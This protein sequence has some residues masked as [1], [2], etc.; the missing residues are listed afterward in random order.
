MDDVISD[1][2]SMLIHE[3]NVW[4]Q[5]DKYISMGAK[6]YLKVKRNYFILLMIYKNKSP[7]WRHT[8]ST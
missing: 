8:E 2:S 1:I 3:E 4:C 6:R 5:W 7:D